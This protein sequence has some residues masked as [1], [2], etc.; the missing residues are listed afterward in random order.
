M[1]QNRKDKNHGRNRRDTLESAIE[2]MRQD[3]PSTGELQSTSSSMWQKLQA[4]VLQPESQPEL[5]QG[6]PD[7]IRL[8]P[9]FHA[10]ELPS[11]RAL[12]VETHLRECATCRHQSEG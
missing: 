9:A 2:A 10:G 4:T 5:I 3:E 11:R 12:L 7:I 8:L 1:T 6:C